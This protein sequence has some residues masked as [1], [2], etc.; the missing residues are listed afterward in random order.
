VVHLIGQKLFSEINS[1]ANKGKLWIDV[2]DTQMDL[3]LKQI[4]KDK[5]DS[6]K[7]AV[8]EKFTDE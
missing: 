4:D 8:R 6:E 7:K 5:Y 3:F 2:L 1:G